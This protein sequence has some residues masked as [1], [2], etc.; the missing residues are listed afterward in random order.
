MIEEEITQENTPIT[1]I[2]STYEKYVEVMKHIA[3]AEER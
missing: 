1:Q 2:A 3:L